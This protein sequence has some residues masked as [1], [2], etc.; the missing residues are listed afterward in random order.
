MNRIGTCLWFDGRA[1]EAAAFYVAIFKNS[2]IV[3]TAHYLEGTPMPAG[4]VLTVRFILD[5]EEFLAL[6]GDLESLIMGPICLA[7]PMVG[8]GTLT[9][10]PRAIKWGSEIT[11][12][13]E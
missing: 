1:E 3:E 4:S 5:G 9:I 8:W 6:N 7:W 2:K 13:G 12:S 10:I 11:S